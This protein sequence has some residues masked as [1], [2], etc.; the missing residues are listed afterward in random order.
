MGSAV[1][2]QAQVPYNPVEV[3][4]AD[5]PGPRKIGGTQASGALS[6]LAALGSG[7]TSPQVLRVVLESPTVKRQLLR[8]VLRRLPTGA[9][10]ADAEDVLLAYLGFR[11]DAVVSSYQVER[12]TFI[13]YFHC[14]LE[15]FCFE[16]ARS[17]R[18]RKERYESLDSADSDRR[19]L[20]EVIANES[21]GTDPVEG[22]VRRESRSAISAA[23]LRLPD[24][25]RKVFLMSWFD[26][27][28]HPE[29]ASRLGISAG[30]VAVLFYRARNALALSLRGLRGLHFQLHVH[31]VN[32]WCGLCQALRAP[33]ALLDAK[34]QAAVV[35]GCDGALNHD[36]QVIV[37]RAIDD[38]VEERRLYERTPLGREVARGS[39]PTELRTLFQSKDVVS[40]LRLNHAL[41]GDLLKAYLTGRSV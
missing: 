12:G 35:A 28:E 33:S 11:L 38:L 18:K 6:G 17:L 7:V 26:G 15:R 32:D 16:K 30:Y 24:Q 20:L 13:H 40:V 41:I 10:P 37:L 4:L 1:M 34:A 21:P 9:T 36:G 29:I 2:K 27:L 8:Y 23:L 3:L 25:Q 5:Q 31:E 39:G 14:C 19:P 22:T